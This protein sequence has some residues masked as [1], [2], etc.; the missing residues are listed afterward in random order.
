VT[1]RLI[2]LATVATAAVGLVA[3]YSTSA[4]AA[5]SAALSAQ[6]ALANSVS[7]NSVAS[8]PAFTPSALPEPEPTGPISATK[9]SV[10]RNVPD[11]PLDGG[12]GRRIVYD[13]ALM[14]VWIVDDAD[15]VVRRY[16]VVGRWDRPLAG[17]YRIYSK[18]E[19][20][21]NSFSKVNFRNMVRFAWGQASDAAIGFH[22]IPVFYAD[23]EFGRAGQRMHGL[24]QLGLPIARGGCVRQ[25]DKDADFL[26]AWSKIGDRVVVLPSP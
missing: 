4:T 6:I 11:Y 17:K 13:K 10:A 8:A 23:T 15:K 2:A 26:Y 12:K 25:S 24:D 20:S 21:S 18:S 19:N 16:P 9:T 1:Q 14:T 3:G 7:A 5:Q 22:T